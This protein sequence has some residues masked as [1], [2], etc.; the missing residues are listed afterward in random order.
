MVR[1]DLESLIFLL[2]CEC[3][4]WHPMQQEYC[5]LIKLPQNFNSVS[6]NFLNFKVPWYLPLGPHQA[7]GPLKLTT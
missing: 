3:P 7:V 2:W 1:K 6:E 4:T 5:I